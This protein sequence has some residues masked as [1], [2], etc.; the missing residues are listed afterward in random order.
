MNIYVQL[1]ISFFKIGLFGFGGGYSIVSLIQSEIL[2]HH[3]MTQTEFTDIVA[4]SQM[5]PSPIGTCAAT[6]VGYTATGGTILG[7]AIALTAVILPSLIIMLT[8]CHFLY[9]LKGNQYL[10]WALAG[11]RP[12]VIGLIGSA[13]L[14]LLNNENFIDYRSIILFFTALVISYRFKTHPIFIII[15]AGILGAILY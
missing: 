9:L 14:I 4:I 11:L 13:V 5:T 6:Y 15:V 12:A 2:E 7:A 1:F 3:W 8:I 10:E